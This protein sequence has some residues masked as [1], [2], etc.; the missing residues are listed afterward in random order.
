LTQPLRDN[1]AANQ[2]QAVSH[3]MS[4]TSLSKYP[5]KEQDLVCFNLAIVLCVALRHTPHNMDLQCHVCVQFKYLV[6]KFTT[7]SSKENS[8][9]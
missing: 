4:A 3:I 7:K 5:L 1:S 8:N 9:L 6:L 2:Q